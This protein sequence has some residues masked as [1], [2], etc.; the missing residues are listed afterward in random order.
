MNITR[1]A[2]REEWLAQRLDLLAKDKAASRQL[3]ALAEQRGAL[4]AVAIDKDYKFEGPDG[5]VALIGLFEAAASCASN[6]SRGCTISTRLPE[7]LVRRGQLARPDP[8]QRRRRYH[9]CAGVARAVCTAW[10]ARP[11]RDLRLP[12][13]CSRGSVFNDYKDKATLVRERLDYFATEGADGQ[14]P[15]VFGQDEG[16]VFHT[17]STY[18]VGVDVTLSTYWFLDLTPIGRQR[19]INDWP[20]HDTYGAPNRHEHDR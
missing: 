10:P 12:W 11:A 15:S 5:K 1:I 19:Y 8:S 20:W 9:A 16:T 6:T 2:S 18:A 17:Y 7:L 13:Y 3:A 4:P 14:G